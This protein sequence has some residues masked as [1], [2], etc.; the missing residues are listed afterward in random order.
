[1]LAEVL[2]FSVAAEKLYMTQ[3]VLSRHIKKLEA[4]LNVQLIDRTTQKVQL[5]SE[6]RTLYEQMPDILARLDNTL[7]RLTNPNGDKMS[8]RL[9]LPY[10]A[11]N[12]Y[13]RDVPIYFEKSHT[14]VS[15]K[16]KFNDPNT[17]IQDLLCDKLDVI[18]V[19]NIPFSGSDQLIFYDIFDE[20]MGVLCNKNDAL[21]SK[22]EIDLNEIEARRILSINSNYF[23][24]MW[25]EIS[26]YSR[27]LG[28]NLLEP[29]I[30]DQMET[31]LIKID[32]G[33]YITIVGQHMK[34]I[35][36]YNVVFVPFANDHFKRKISLCYKKGNRNPVIK[37][38]KK[39]Y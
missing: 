20:K 6:G 27:Q 2:N 31:L 34:N 29:D 7:S 8:I 13:L 4:N 19:P 36:M 12:D 3:P 21:A 18:I 25:Q 22:S 24:T 11:I 10:Y 23:N 14:D 33:Q 9:G 1:M 32:K 30:F 26:D 38:L 15:L 17:L 28:Y 39:A 35:S 37:L 16:Y 5:T